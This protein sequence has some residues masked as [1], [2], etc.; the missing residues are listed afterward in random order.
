MNLRYEHTLARGWKRGLGIALVAVFLGGCGGGEDGQPG[1][2]EEA[3]A[4]AEK[5][6]RE[7]GDDWADGF[8]SLSSEGCA[9]MD[10]AICDEY[11]YDPAMVRGL[12][13]TPELQESFENATVTDVEIVSDTEARAQFSNGHYVD[14]EEQEGIWV[15]T[16]PGP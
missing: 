6:I 4:A 3:A 13:G 7:I 14:F 10:P 16:D 2:G 11:I 15:V 5:E 9:Y 8:S 1:G 12:E